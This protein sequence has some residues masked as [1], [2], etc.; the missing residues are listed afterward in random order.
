MKSFTFLKGSLS[1]FLVAMMAATASH[2]QTAT[3]SPLNATIITNSS[4]QF[5]V[6]TTG[7]GGNNVNRT[8]DY[9][10]SGPGATIPATPA[11][12]NCSN[13]CNSES[14]TFQF[15]T[16]GVYTV[17]VTVTRNSNPAVTATTSTT[18]N[19]VA[20]NMWVTSAEGTEIS[21][22]AVSNG[23]YL[24]GPSTIFN[25]TFPN[26][27]NT[28]TRTAALGRNASPSPVNGHFYWLG[29]SSGSSQNNG[30]VEVFA[31]TAVGGSPTRIGT[32]DL[33]GAGNGA[34]LGFVRLGMGAD[35]TGWILAGDGS[36][37]YLAK[38]LS[39]G[40]NPVTIVMEDNSVN[41]SGGN[42]ATFQ[43]GDVCISGN[44]N[45]YALAN[46]GNGVTQIFIGQPTG[47]TTTLT[48]R[49]D[50]VDENND[51]FTGSVNGV[52]FDLL[53]SL[54]LTTSQGLFYVDQGT[55]NGPAG[56]VQCALVVSQTGLQD[57]ASNVFPTQ[58]TLPVTLM[59]FT[60]SYKDGVT[61][62]NW[63]TENE[64]N[65]SHYEVERK[66]QSSGTAFMSIGTKQALGNT[67]QSNYQLVDNI[68][69]VSDE[70]LYYRV[71]MVDIDGKYKYSNV[72]MVRKEQKTITGIQISPNPVISGHVATIRFQSS[73]AATVSLRVMDMA[74][75]VMMQ[76]Q[77]RINE[78]VNSIAVNNLDRL[79]PGIYI[80]QM[81]NGAELSAIKLSVVR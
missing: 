39:N 38:F 57:L 18:L 4:Q 69:S 13:G 33:N 47:N 66:G 31:S 79:Q 40:V 70:V 36:N 16:A 43:N 74:G 44:N 46:D 56:T 50:L 60:G 34:E 8:F 75:R 64:V 32:L 26:A 30:L 68:S 63:Q 22:Y 42:V 48:R 52:A 45:I 59:S 25:P 27:T 51:P 5:T 76:Q 37:L 73:A 9:T 72:I 12:Y 35:G 41:L 14:H 49:W 80:I 61:T 58:S 23:N 78:G 71:K 55:V 1:V 24:A 67:G 15:P 17:T 10:I 65:F 21:G 53:G 28:Y 19:V 6:S 7:F 62:L 3:I 29:T 54:Y 20:A 11:S 77:N 2:S 81:Q